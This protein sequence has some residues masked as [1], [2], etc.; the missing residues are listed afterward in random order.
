M[1]K[2]AELEARYAE[3]GVPVIVKPGRDVV[4]E[5]DNEFGLQ[6]ESPKGGKSL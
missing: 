4:R 1:A 3:A 6:A 2:D 5:I